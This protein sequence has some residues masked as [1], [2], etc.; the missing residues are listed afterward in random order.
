[1]TQE[2]QSDTI[3]KKN[4]KIPQLPV[5]G[6]QIS[7][8]VGKKICKVSKQIFCE[9]KI[10][11]VYLQTNFIQV[12]N[13]NEK[14]V[15]GADILNK[16]AAQI[17]FNENNIQFRVD[18]ATHIIPFA[19]KEPRVVNEQEQVLNVEINES[20]TEGDQITLPTKKAKYSLHY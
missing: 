8:A 9:C 13:L 12:E 1:L 6:V 19:N 7:N 16:Y 11:D 18:G 20:N 5:T 14:S 3:T 2:Q 10:G 15:I 17:K 4:Q